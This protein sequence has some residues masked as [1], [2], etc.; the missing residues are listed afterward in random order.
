M[1]NPVFNGHQEV[2][3]SLPGSKP[4][5][6]IEIGVELLLLFPPP[7]SLL[8][9]GHAIPWKPLHQ[10][11]NPAP[12]SRGRPFRISSRL[13]TNRQ[14]TLFPELLAALAAGKPF[15]MRNL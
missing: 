8:A 9:A 4:F 12:E 3:C 7:A 15:P 10:Q 5:G 11:G 13:S 6:Q 14:D 1:P 2:L